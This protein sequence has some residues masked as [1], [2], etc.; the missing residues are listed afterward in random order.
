MNELDEL[1][2]SAKEKLTSAILGIGTGITVFIAICWFIT[3]LIWDVNV[4]KQDRIIEVYIL[5]GGLSAVFGL[6]PSILFGALASSRYEEK[7]F[8]G[9]TTLR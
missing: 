1:N 9:R 6:V 4:A 2:L 7:L 3:L 5:V 8:L